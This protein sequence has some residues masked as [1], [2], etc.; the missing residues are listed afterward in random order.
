VI[1][2]WGIAEWFNAG[3]AALWLV[4]AVA[5]A[6]NS[7]RAVGAR[8]PLA[9]IAAIAFALFAG[10]DLVE[11]ST[12]AWWSPWWLLAW[13]TAC[14]AMLLGCGVAWWRSRRRQSDA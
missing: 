13:K 11:I 14:V 4:V 10:S 12:G 9:L 5:C 7:R 6:V 1:S 8:R 3:E 2:A